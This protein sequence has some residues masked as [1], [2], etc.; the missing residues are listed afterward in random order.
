MRI[1]LDPVDAA[2]SPALANPSVRLDAGV[3][4]VPTIVAAC[5]KV[6]F[7]TDNLTP[8]G[9]ISPNWAPV[10]TSYGRVPR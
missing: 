5:T 7:F 3:L 2:T 1:V 8:T 6:R 4:Q 10:P 9:A